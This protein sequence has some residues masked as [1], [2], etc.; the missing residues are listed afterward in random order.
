M[1]RKESR[2]SNL[3]RSQSQSNF[4]TPHH[5]GSE[6]YVSN[7]SPRVG[8]SITLRVRIPKRYLFEKSFVRLYEDGEPRSYELTLLEKGRHE[9]WWGV[10]VTMANKT[11][12][13]R[14][15]FLSSEKYEWLTARGLFD[16]D[17]HS[18]TDFKLFSGTR[19]PEWVYSAVFYQIFPDRFAKSD[20]KRELPS[21]A[22]PRNWSDLPAQKKSEISSELYGGDLNGVENHIDYIEELGVNGIYFTPFF[23]ALSNHRYDA[24][25]FTEADPL[26]GGNEA[27]QSLVKTAHSRGIRI[28]GDLTSNHCGAGHPWLAK[29]LE[30]SK[31]P[32]RAFFYWDSSVPHGYIGWWGVPSLPKLNFNSEELRKRM[33]SADDSIVKQ[34]LTPARGLAGWR[35]DVGNMTGRQG[36]DDL[37]DEV[38]HG[39]RTAMDGAGEEFWLV[40]ENGDFVASDLDGYGWHGAMNYQ[41]FLRPVW[42]WLQLNSEIGGGFQGL[43]FQMPKFTGSQLVSS[44]QEF[45][46]AIPWDSY[47]S[48]ML[49]LD[50]HDTARMRTV[51]NGDRSRHLS[52]MALALTIPG[53]PS[54]YAGDEIGLEGSN[55]EA[56]RRTMDWDGHANWD[57]DFLT[58]VKAL[59]Q[60]RRTHDALIHGGLRWL[61]IGDDYLLFARESKTESLLIFISRS[62]VNLSIDLEP[63][64]LQITKTVFGEEQSGC[65]LKLNSKSATQGIWSI[66]K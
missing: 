57:F 1:V 64:G 6:L 59:I 54:I 46:S 9:D 34:W 27:L 43:P 12:E 53:V 30:D 60:I 44:M 42:N 29:A 61:E 5:D 7:H 10:T 28:L 14:F 21:W 26:L 16:H 48:C 11:L 62:G 31:S 37:H 32:E 52:G 3:Q 15:V 47:I 19:A 41:G 56:G 49:L 13:Y 8:D 25:S 65:A 58:D 63:F 2:V 39:I 51:V 17:V 24:S 40:A 38:M 36:D 23:P 45:S 35:I 18:N 20:V 22:T 55:G 4:L 66:R 33:Y 50:S